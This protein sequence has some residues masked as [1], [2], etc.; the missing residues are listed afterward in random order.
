MRVP[1]KF[2]VPGD[3]SWPRLS[4]NVKLGVRIAA[5]RSAGR[6]VKDHPERK[7]ELD[8]MGFEW[9]LRDTKKGETSKAANID[10]L[11]ESVYQA[12]SIYQRRHGDVE[13]PPDYEVSA[14]NP[15]YPEEL[16]GLP[17]GGHV[18]GLKEKN[19]LIFGRT[20]REDRLAQL[21][22]VWEQTGRALFSKKRFE[23]V[24]EGLK[25]YKA[26]KGDLLVPQA[27][28]V[29]ETAEWPEE[30]WNLKL[31]ARVN[32]IRS[33]GTLVA[34]SP[35]RRE[36][37][38]KLGFEWELPS[39]IKRR[40][41]TRLLQASGNTI[42]AQPSPGPIEEVPRG[43]RGPKPT[44]YTLDADGSAES[45][46]NLKL[47]GSD[48]YLEGDVF[49]NSRDSFPISTPDDNSALGVYGE[50]GEDGEISLAEMLPDEYSQL[51]MSIQRGALTFDPSRMFEPLSHREISSEAMRLLMQEREYSEDPDMRQYAHFEGHLTPENYH[52]VT[53][54]KIPEEDIKAMKKV[55]YKILEFGR[56]N[57]DIFKDALTAYH[58]EHGN[59]DVPYDYTITSEQCIEE[60]NDYTPSM[61]GLWLGEYVQAIR[62]GDIDGLEETKRRKF[63]DSLGFDW[64]DKTKHL[65]FRFVPM[66]L[67]LRIFR[68][69][70]GFAYPTENWVVPD[71]RQWPYWMAGMPLG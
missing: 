65:R 26:L 69:L 48:N 51:Q 18:Q 17:L 36:L 20:D 3:D 40:E 68:H 35:S 49:F 43:Q 14:D 54:R 52:H 32:A 59:V 2:I 44:P 56:F 34:N 38:D 27:F 47:K 64:G 60:D 71:A 70:Y 66:L 1:S 12:L 22:F 31:G 57:W 9:R 23:M 16:H 63:L 42:N 7:A 41:K 8:N 13:V 24:Y 55:G 50:D 33:Q 67:G 4:R 58:A 53:K 15:D 45:R 46:T 61:A 29:P 5:I 30:C 19:N 10:D 11:F 28:V 39:T 37:L 62:I 25:T 6:Y 21:G